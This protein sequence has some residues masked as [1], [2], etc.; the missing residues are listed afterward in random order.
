MDKSL[1][2]EHWY[3]VAEIKVRLR[4]HARI[5]RYHFRGK[6]WYMLQDRTSGRYHRFTPATYVV[7]SLFDGE[8]TVQD[9][10]DMA[11]E[12][13]GDDVLTQG[14]MLQL[15]AQLHA[16]NV[17]Y[18]DVPPDLDEM[19]ARANKQQR[20]KLVMSLINPL[21]IRVP[22]L[23][24][25]EFLN[26]TFPIVRPIFSWI[27]A[28]LFIVIVSYALVLA[29]THWSELTENIT[30][31]VLATESQLLLLLTY[32]FVKIL[33]ELGHGYALKK[34][35]GEVHE[36]G[37]MFLVFMPVPYIDASDVSSFHEKWRRALVSAA[38]ILVELFLAAIAMFIWV[39]AEEG[40]VRA[41]AFNV[42]LIG[43]VSTVLFNGNPLLRFDGYYV[44][45][46]LIEIP[47]LGQRANQYLGYLIQR[48]LFSVEGLDSPITAPG[49]A[50]W[51]FWYSILAFIYR[52]FI[53]VSI[54]SFVATKFFVIGIMMAI[55]AVILM[56]VVPLTKQLLFL[57][58]SPVLYHQRGR[59]I[60]VS[61]TIF[62][63]VAAML[64]L[65]PVP[66]ATVTEGVIWAPDDAIVYVSTEG[67]ISELL[68]SPNS[69]VDRGDVLLRIEDPLLEAEHRILIEKRNEF[70]LRYAAAYMDDPVEAKIVSEQLKHAQ[71]DLELTQHKLE[72]LFV[73]SPDNGLFVLSRANDLLGRFFR[74]GEVIGY[75]IQPRNQVVRV[76]V[77]ED[78]ADLVRVQ[79]D[80]V[81]VKLSEQI[82]K[83]L[84]ATI[85]R[86]VPAFSNT[87]PS[88]AL[89]TVGGGEIMMNPNANNEMIALTN[90]MHLELRLDVPLESVN[91][92]ERVYVRF[93][94][95]MQPLA[96]RIYRTVR[97]VF[98]RQFNV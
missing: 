48:Y 70:E 75:V 56:V 80:K 66:Y 50:M 9:V 82:G 59:A 17:L 39:S 25:E 94:H 97:Q 60:G 79:V 78:Q 29:G 46:D 4:G 13:L 30:D 52:C 74:K 20:R 61:A 23:D 21:A 35:G 18:G 63:A 86:E 22:V 36:I 41:F 3:R 58:T 87:L 83:S 42:M 26:A 84:S 1:F 93:S 95:G 54:V 24:P 37:F 27:G 51:L 81:E 91:L 16:C 15:L 77:N 98:L 68:V 90:L 38:G 7:I 85:E 72:N 92:G 28:L 43:G 57:F 19:T 55:W 5:H 10:W 11:C 34:W 6:L 40:L 32:P 62:S 64:L 33:H 2:S 47:N 67:V 49:E 14:E 88:A 69:K 45:S 96:T 73:K 31:R 71:A 76:V 44:F 12:Q 8:R 89:S 53:V 65:V